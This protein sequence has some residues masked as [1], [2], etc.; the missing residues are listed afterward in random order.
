MSYESKR[1][2]PY[3]HQFLPVLCDLAGQTNKEKEQAQAK[4]K[5][6][7]NVLKNW[8]QDEVPYIIDPRREG[9]FKGLKTD[10]ERENFIE[11]FWLRRDPSPDTIGQRIPG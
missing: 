5:R 11:Q 4:K 1:D 10:E 9:A 6:A 3:P 8:P 7:G 2:R